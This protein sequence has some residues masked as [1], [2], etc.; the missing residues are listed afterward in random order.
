MVMTVREA[1]L[2]CVYNPRWDGD[3]C[4]GGVTVLCATTLGGM[5]M[6][7]REA[8]LY[9]VYNPRWNGDDCEGGV[10]VLCVQP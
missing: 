7:V 4:E 2:Y 5:V 6:T 1:S 9:C 8:S 10:T 3:D